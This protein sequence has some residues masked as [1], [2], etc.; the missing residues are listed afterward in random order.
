MSKNE[1]LPGLGKIVQ[2]AV[3]E[4]SNRYP[5]LSPT[6]ENHAQPTGEKNC[7]F[8]LPSNPHPNPATPFPPPPPNPAL[9]KYGSFPT[10]IPNHDGLY[11]LIL[12]FKNIYDKAA[13]DCVLERHHRLLDRSIL[14]ISRT[15]LRTWNGK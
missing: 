10:T 5:G 11:A 2:G 13:A 3:G 7:M 1:K 8:Q 12:F 15:V 14:L 6:Q 9:K 4:K